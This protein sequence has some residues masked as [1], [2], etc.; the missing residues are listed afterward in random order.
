MSWALEILSLASPIES[1]SIYFCKLLA[2]V[3]MLVRTGIPCVPA[4]PPLGSEPV[5]L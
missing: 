3:Q 5:C 4:G 1:E 2:G